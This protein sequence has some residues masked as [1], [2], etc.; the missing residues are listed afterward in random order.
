[1]PA[2]KWLGV[3]AGICL[4]LALGLS[5]AFGQAEPDQA[6]EAARIAGVYEASAEALDA[7]Q[8]QLHRETF[9]VA[10]LAGTLN[11]KSAQEIAA[12]VGENIALTAYR[13]VL[14]GAQGT[15]EDRRGNSLDRALLIV[16]L[17]EANGIEAR[18][19]RASLDETSATAL[20]AAANGVPPPPPAPTSDAAIFEAL[21]ADPRIDAARMRARTE[22]EQADAAAQTAQANAN[23]AVIAARLEAEA[24]TVL[25]AQGGDE[26]LAAIADHWW[27]QAQS[28]GA[29]SNLDPSAGIVG[30]L[31]AA[32]THGADAVPQDLRRTVTVRVVAEFSRGGVL[33]RETLLAR[34]FD[35]AAISGRVLVLRHRPLDLKSFDAIFAEGGDFDAKVIAAVAASSAWVPML[36]LGGEVATDRLVA[37]DGDVSEA[38]EAAM[39][40]HGGGNGVGASLGGAIDAID[41][42]GE[43]P[44]GPYDENTGPVKFTAE[45]V[46]IETRAPGEAPRI[47][48]RTLFDLIGPAARARRDGSPAIADAGRK[49]RGF[50][51]LQSIEILVTTGRLSPER[52]A[53]RINESFGTA[54]RATAAWLRAADGTPAPAL[55]DNFAHVNLPLTAFAAGRLGYGPDGDKRIQ[56]EP[57]V[58]MTR[59]GL[60][61]ATDGGLNDALTFDIVMNRVRTA[62][63]AAAIAAGVADTVA[64]TIAIGAPNSQSSAAVRFADALSEGQSWLLIEAGNLAALQAL[65]L[66]P[67]SEAL[68]AEDLER[69]YAVVVPQRIASL[70]E[71]VWWRIDPATGETLGMNAMGGAVTVE[72]AINMT[73]ALANTASCLYKI[74]Q[75]GA[76]PSTGKVVGIGLC[77]LGASISIAG[78]LA[79]AQVM[80]QLG[81]VGG[82]LGVAGNFADP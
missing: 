80:W 51:L 12:W 60:R 16:A 70:E 39:A 55:P 40:K 31:S 18:L 66:E 26:R 14:K 64:E 1:M 5:G 17:L 76:N 43:E 78:A 61:P 75:A 56:V 54:F 10:A 45:F 36:A 47:E 20:L 72:Y 28:G 11:G 9:D 42:M 63:A 15:L 21:Y 69:G 81:S 33:A 79:G 30:A 74:S 25:T 57:N 46:E 7:M 22:R 2:P 13:G 27:V 68:V 23:I 8:A 59:Q 37:T 52:A 19:A 32:E 4:P 73:I 71:A 65:D 3:A 35:P 67:D 62:D 49:A 34:D 29:W 58:A 53:A 48:R 82:A 41:A 38:T 77:L 50:A 24:A 6:A 44:A